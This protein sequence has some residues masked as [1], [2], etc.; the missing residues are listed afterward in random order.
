M[1]HRK[2]NKFSKLN[3]LTS[4][5]QYERKQ[6]F[7]LRNRERNKTRYYVDKELPNPN[8]NACHRC[9]YESEERYVRLPQGFF[10]QNLICQNCY[11]DILYNVYH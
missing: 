2:E 3:R 1:D 8:I 9:H 7:K 11:S 6:S 5:G 4:R 10:V